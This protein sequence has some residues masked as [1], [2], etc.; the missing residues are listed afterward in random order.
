MV[1]W[2][3]IFNL[4][5]VLLP[6]TELVQHNDAAGR[7]DLRAL[8]DAPLHNGTSRPPS[9]REVVNFLKEFRACQLH[10]TTESLVVQ[11]RTRF[12]VPPASIQHTFITT[13]AW[14]IFSSSRQ[15]RIRYNPHLRLKFPT[16]EERVVEML[17][18]RGP[19]AISIPLSIASTCSMNPDEHS[20]DEV[21]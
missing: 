8:G 6:R 10:R 11:S 20:T 3:L 18:R 16:L 17:Y 2:Y 15:D 9:S 5:Q 1:T 7:M 13:R 21:K 4:E 14:F 19:S 12:L